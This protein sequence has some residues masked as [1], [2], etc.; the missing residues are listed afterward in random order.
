M[1]INTVNPRDFQVIQGY[2]DGGFRISGQRHEGP[3]LVLPSRTLAWPVFDLAAAT[4]ESFSALA[5]ERPPIE[6]LLLGTGARMRTIAPSLRRALRDLYGVTVEV[7]DSG[8]ACRT[9][10]V[11]VAELRPVAAALLATGP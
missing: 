2:G 8:A 11:L 1:E 5:D 7:M 10:N 9:Y 6:V 3:V 4:A